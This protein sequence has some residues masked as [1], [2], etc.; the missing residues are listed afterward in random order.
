MIIFMFSKGDVSEFEDESV[1]RV[2]EQMILDRLKLRGI[3]GITKVSRSLTSTL[4]D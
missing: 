3:S 1:I 4:S 2:V